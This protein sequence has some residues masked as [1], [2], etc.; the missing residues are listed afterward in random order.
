MVT[1]WTATSD[2]V[3]KKHT[4]SS[5]KTHKADTKPTPCRDRTCVLKAP[6]LAYPTCTVHEGSIHAMCNGAPVSVKAWGVGS[7]GEAKALKNC[8]WAAKT[9]KKWGACL[10]LAEADAKAVFNEITG[11]DNNAHRTE[12]KT[13]FCPVGYFLGISA[14]D[15]QHASYKTGEGNKTHSGETFKTCHTCPGGT[16]SNGGTSTSC[17]APTADW[18]QC[19]HVACKSVTYEHKCFHTS[20]SPFASP[21]LDSE[22][23]MTSQ[24]GHQTC[25]DAADTK[26]VE[27]ISVVSTDPQLFHCRASLVAYPTAAT[28]TT[29]T[30]PTPISP[31]D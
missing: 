13:Q 19:T 27:R 7:Q 18:Q 2:A 5:Y 4:A 28:T 25:A 26:N 1:A 30:Q 29:S 20:T 31:T 3:C 17:F 12:L 10:P 21:V 16:T 9:Q 14:K 22:R 23:H 15:T 24:N 6:A 8:N 11:T